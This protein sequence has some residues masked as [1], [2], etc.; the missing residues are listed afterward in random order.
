MVTAELA[1]HHF[2][3]VGGLHRSGTTIITRCLAEHPEIS[4]FK[5]TGAQEDEGQFLQSVYPIGRVHGGPGAFG[6]APEA[7][8][9]EES[10]LVSVENRDQ[11]FSGWSRHWDLGRPVLMEKSPPNIIRTRFLQAQFPRS[12]FLIVVRHPVAVTFATFTRRPKRTRVDEL[13]RHWVHCHEILERDLPHLDRALIV[14]YEGFVADPDATLGRVYDFL[15]LPHHPNPL[16]IRGETND[17]YYRMWREQTSRR[18]AGRRTRL[19][20]TQL[21]ARV[22]RFGYSL[23]D[24]GFTGPAPSLTT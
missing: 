2:L 17:R 10:P 6:F 7:S 3:F 1:N 16:P 14:P 21:E 12:W 19:A 4:G 20:A 9:T 22:R 5:D 11:M 15:G 24:L 13:L 8:L 18:V 23:D